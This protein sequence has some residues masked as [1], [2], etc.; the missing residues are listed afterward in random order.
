MS[1]FLLPQNARP[2]LNISSRTHF[3]ADFISGHLDLSKATGAPIVY[4]PETDAKFKVHIAK[5]G[6]TFSIG[7]LTVQ[8]LHTPGHTLESACYL[9]KMKMEK[10]IASSQSDTLF[11]GDVGR[12]SCT[13][14]MI[15]LRLT[16]RACCT[17]TCSRRSF[18]GRRCDRISCTRP[19]QLM[20][21]NMSPVH[22]AP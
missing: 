1:T 21:Q 20:W 2:A 18:P 6:E 3:H 15:L 10:T 11:V 7:N 14:E 16:W 9:L 22:Q 19:R 17:I 13:K 4:G 8:A 12:R 5:D